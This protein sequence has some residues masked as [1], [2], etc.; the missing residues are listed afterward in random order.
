M[1]TT[2]LITGAGSGLGRDLARYIAAWQHKVFVT[3]A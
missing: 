1:A 2:F 3:D